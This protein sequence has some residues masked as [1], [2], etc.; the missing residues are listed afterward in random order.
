MNHNGLKGPTVFTDAQKLLIYQDYKKLAAIQFELAGNQYQFQLRTKDQGSK[1]FVIKG[2]IDGQG[3][4]TI[5]ER[6]PTFA[7]CPICLAAHTQID[8]PN[9]PIA[10]ENLRV[11]DLVWT[12]NT[13]DARVAAAILVVVQVPVPAGHQIVHLILADGRELWASPGHP[14]SD[15][16]ALG[17]PKAGDLLDGARVVLAE[18]VPY[19]QS[20]TYDLLPSGETGFYWANGILIGSTLMDNLP[21]PA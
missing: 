5:Q 12:V 16:R 14:T 9:G 17:D 13:S 8:T 19:S 7:T 6:T 21:L 3:N 11:G 2:L 20:F 10:V 4:I 18:R 15:G 1:G